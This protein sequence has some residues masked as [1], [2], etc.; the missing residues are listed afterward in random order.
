MTSQKTTIR[1]LRERTITSQPAAGESARLIAITYQIAPLPPNV[2]FIP[3]SE[4]PDRQWVIDNPE[5]TEIP[6]EVQ[7]AG[8][9]VRRQNILANSRR[10]DAQPAR[11]I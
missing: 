8:D 1:I 10:E 5:L 9:G 6:E 7:Q 11:T 4:L 3:E 2:V